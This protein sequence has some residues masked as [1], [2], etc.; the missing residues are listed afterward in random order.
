MGRKA[1]GK[2]F[3]NDTDSLIKYSGADVGLFNLQDIKVTANGIIL[4]FCM[5]EWYSTV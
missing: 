4:F 3:S 2:N 1:S 5:A